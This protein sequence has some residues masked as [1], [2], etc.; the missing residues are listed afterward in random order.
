MRESVFERLIQASQALPGDVRLVLMDGWRPKSVQDKLFQDIRQQVADEHPGLPA[1]EIDRITLQ[2]AA[3]PSDD[4]QRPSPH[5]TGG[6]VDV[7]LADRAGRF[8]D[9]GSE[10][11]EPSEWS[12][13]AAAV[14]KTHRER[15]DLL[16]RA[17][18]EAGFTNL[19][20]EW[21]HFDFGNWVWAWYSD[22]PSAIYGPAGIS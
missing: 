12:W 6:S 3:R 2:F 17:M 16:L 14:S 19:P 13:T 22:E 1:A 9:M 7:T 11:D 5:I 15:R 21:W 20:S 8:L 4:P 10:F 18:S